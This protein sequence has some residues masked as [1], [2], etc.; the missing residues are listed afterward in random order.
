M[1]NRKNF[2]QCMPV[3]PAISPLAWRSPSTK[4]AIT[5]TLPPWRS[6]NLAVLSSRS[7][8]RKMYFP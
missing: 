8:V 6:K 4:R 7:G 3:I 1:L 2:F 5:I